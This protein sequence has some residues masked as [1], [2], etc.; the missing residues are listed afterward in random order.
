MPPTHTTEGLEAALEI[1]RRLPGVAVLVLSAYTE[2]E[3]ATEL[4]SGGGGVG[5]LLKSRVMDVEEFM[6]ALDRVSRAAR[7]SIP[8]WSASCS[9]SS[10]AAIRWAS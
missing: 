10:G 6:G 8:G 9:R 1:R 5:Y 4:I 7:S 3:Q 2:L